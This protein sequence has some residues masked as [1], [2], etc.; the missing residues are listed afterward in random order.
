MQAKYVPPSQLNRS[1]IGKPMML[2]L[3]NGSE[4]YGTMKEIHK[5]GIVFV[6]SKLKNDNVQTSQ[7][8]PFVPFF[9][10][11]FFFVPFVFF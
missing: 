8:F 1:H 5:N 9:V 3:K 11:F 2:R 6:P 10:P 7:F 4:V